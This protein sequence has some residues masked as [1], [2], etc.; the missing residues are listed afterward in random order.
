[1]NDLPPIP[2]DLSVSLVAF[3]KQC[4]HKSPRWRQSAKELSQHEWLNRGLSKVRGSEDIIVNPCANTSRIYRARNLK[5]VTH[6][7]RW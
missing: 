2:E 3:L 7:H 4:F 5:S 1:M 6:S